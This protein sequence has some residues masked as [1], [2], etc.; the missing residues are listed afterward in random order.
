[1]QGIA[2]FRLIYQRVKTLC[3]QCPDPW[4]CEEAAGEVGGA[5]PEAL[6]ECPR[7]VPARAAPPC[8][9]PAK[10]LFYTMPTSSKIS[11]KEMNPNA[12]NVS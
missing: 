1:M 3:S 4:E 8:L 2:F 10:H 7:N 6:T 11:K 9:G 12:V 5:E